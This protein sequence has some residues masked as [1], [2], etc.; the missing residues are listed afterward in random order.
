MDGGDNSVKIPKYKEPTASGFDLFGLTGSYNKGTN[1]YGVSADP[2]ELATMQAVK[3]IRSSLLQSLGLGGTPESDPYTQQYMNEI[4]RTSQGPLENALIGRG[5]GGSTVYKDA[6]TDLMSKAATQAVLGGQQ[7]KQNN[8]A[9]L[10]DY[11]NTN[12]GYGQDLLGRVTSQY[13]TDQTNSWQRYKDLL[14]LN[15]YNANQPKD[16][17]PWGSI[18]SLAGMGLALGA[19]PFTGGASLALIPAA[20]AMGGGIGGLFDKS[21]SGG[22]GG[23]GGGTD[24]SALMS[25]FSRGNTANTMFGTNT[26]IAPADYYKTN[27]AYAF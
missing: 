18:G 5:L 23:G 14:G 20:G 8:L 12:M 17:T 3:G 24:L 22:G 10:N 26:P 4:L 21:G 16:T 11:I 13:N 7:Y 19:A 9:S 25:L 15:L 6:L 27:A 2:Q 1:T